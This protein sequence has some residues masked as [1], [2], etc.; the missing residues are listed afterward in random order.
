[1]FVVLEYMD[2]GSLA[3]VHRRA[4]HRRFP[5]YVASDFATQLVRGLHYMHRE[6]YQVHRDIK[7]A[8]MLCDRSGILL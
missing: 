3:D 8:N 2:A 1:M 6:K 7:P 5:E 4:E